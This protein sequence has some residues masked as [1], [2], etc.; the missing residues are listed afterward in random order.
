MYFVYVLKCL[1]KKKRP[2]YVGVTS[3]LLI[4]LNQHN[5]IFNKGYTKGHKWELV[6]AEGYMRLTAAYNRERKLKQHGNVWY[7]MMRRVRY[8]LK[9]E[10]NADP[11]KPNGSAL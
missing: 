8:S 10:Q 2:Y 3:N 5:S 6:Y 4:R 7:G 9:C 1:E 11:S